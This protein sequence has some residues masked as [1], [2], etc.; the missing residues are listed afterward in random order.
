LD[1]NKVLEVLRNKHNPDEFA[2]F[3]ELRIGGGYGK[4]SE[5]RFDAWAINYRPSK[6][7]KTICYE[8]KVSR[9]D[10]FNEI[11][12]PF[13]RRAGLRLAN[14]FYF[15][16]PAGML[17]V[18]EIPPEC[19]LM[20]VH[21]EGYITTVIHAPF[22]NV[23]PP[24]FNF[25]ATICRRFDK[26]RIAEFADYKRKLMRE[27]GEATAAITAINNHIE[28]WKSWNYGNKEVPDKIAAAIES[29]KADIE[30]IIKHINYKE[31][32]MD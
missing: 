19:G 26:D 9:S 29:L 17:K 22:R 16:V 1:S 28:R 20:E 27:K 23:L 10:F 2:F 11:K 21:P 18:E 5:Q 13:K 30:D 3:S 31:I 8:I 12:K 24:T 6:Q 25:L 14:E 4:D 15:V 7:N 32:E